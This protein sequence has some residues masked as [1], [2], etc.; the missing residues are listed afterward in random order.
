MAGLKNEKSTNSV[1][2]FEESN[3]T[4]PKA[5][6]EDFDMKLIPSDPD[7]RT[8]VGRI[9]DKDIDLQPDFQRGEVWSEPKQR[10]LIDSILRD[11]HVPPIHVVQNPE[12]NTQDV[13][14]GQQRLAAIRDFVNGVFAVDG[15]IE[16][17]AP[18]IEDLHG[19]RYEQLP[20]IWKRKFDQFTIRF[21]KIIDFEPEEPAELFFRLNQP[22]AL[23]SAEQRNAFYGPI[24][25]QVKDFVDLLEH[26]P[27]GFS[28]SRM[29]LDDVVARVCVAIETRTI[30]KKLTSSQLTQRYRSKL[31]FSETTLLLCHYAVL[32][33]TKSSEE[34][35]EKVKLNKATVF[36]WLWASACSSSC[37]LDET[38][39]VLANAIIQSERIRRTNETLPEDGLK[40]GRDITIKGDRCIDL[41]QLYVD[42]SSSRVSDVSSVIARDVLIR[43]FLAD[44]CARLNRYELLSQTYIQVLRDPLVDFLSSN[45]MTSNDFINELISVHSW[46]QL[47]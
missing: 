5:F 44:S 22:V 13:L 17:I 19:L 20:P 35:T 2:K 11:W 34:W 30:A 33:F 25:T 46:G 32:N 8:I 16:P 28:N 29:A 45:D 1:S 15:K 14:D 27:F 40:F 43:I 10:R 3:S 23:T 39:T 18:E 36:S 42:R 9:K 21:F 4:T 37:F 38:S 41:V 24:R 47:R 7:V 6:N 26:V 31:A 12:T